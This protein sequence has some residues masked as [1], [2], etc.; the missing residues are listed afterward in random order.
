M[1]V[2]IGNIGLLRDADDFS[3]EYSFITESLVRR[4]HNGGHEVYAWTVDTSENMDRMINMGVDNIIT[5]DVP[6]GRDRIA[7]S[8]TTNAV[9]DLIG[10]MQKIFG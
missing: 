6:L 2:A 5:D 4:L 1:S 7:K 3:I 8:R 9:D 10:Y